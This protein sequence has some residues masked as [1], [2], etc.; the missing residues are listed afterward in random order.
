MDSVPLLRDAMTSLN[1]T[2]SRRDR[3][4]RGLVL[5]AL[6]LVASGL[7]HGGVWL[8]DGMAPLGGPVS[9]RKPIVFGLSS[10]ITTFSVAWLVAHLGQSASRARWVALY[11]VTMAIEIFLID[12]QRW[13]GVGSHYNVATP[14]DALVFGAMGILICLSVAAVAVLGWRFSRAASV[15]EDQRAAGSAGVVLLLVG[16]FIGGWMA[17][18]GSMAG[19]SGGGLWKLPHG[20]ALHAIQTLPVLG[21]WLQRRGV[22]LG[23]RR[24]IILL[25]AAA[26]GVL[27]VL[28]LAIAAAW[29]L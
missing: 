27:V 1:E 26:H 14:F 2:L 4:V 3:A 11:A 18:H 22:N 21:W 8:F 17:S 9:W 23:A 19:A 24:Q 6:V 16:S 20:L 29:G 7:V 28:G 12:L 15:P 25:A 5:M 10:G 13:R